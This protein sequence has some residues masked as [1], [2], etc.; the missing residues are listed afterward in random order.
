MLLHQ[1]TTYQAVKSSA[2]GLWQHDPFSW[3]VQRESF[4]D[5]GHLKPASIRLDEILDSWLFEM[6]IDDRM[7][8]IEALY[9]VLGATNALTV[10]DL[11]GN[12]LK[13]AGAVLSVLRHMD[14]SYRHLVLK[15]LGGLVSAAVGGGKEERQTAEP[16]ETQGSANSEGLALET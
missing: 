12:I 8:L 15:K 2:S 11:R 1:H 7:A 4:E 3:C 13:N 10:N 5:A 16:A 14:G 9:A 6:S